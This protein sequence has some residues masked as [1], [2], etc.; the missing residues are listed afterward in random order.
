MST[1]DLV[2]IQRHLLGL[3]PLDSPYKMIAAD[4]NNSESLTAIDLVEIRKLI[5]GLYLEFPN[6]ASWRFV[7][8]DFVFSS[9]GQMIDIINNFKKKS[10]TKIL[11]IYSKNFTEEFYLKKFNKIIKNEKN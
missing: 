8:K 7:D 4:A 1:L 11:E 10:K 3:D 9:Q 6:N 5:L 2:D